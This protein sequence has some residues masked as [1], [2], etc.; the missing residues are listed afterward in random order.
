MQC[1]NRLKT[2]FLPPCSPKGKGVLRHP[3]ALQLDEIER[4][5]P[6]ARPTKNEHE[7]RTASLPAIRVTQAE[8]VL[9]EDKAATAGVSLSD[10]MRVL[11]LTEQV[12]P[13]QTKLEASLLVELNRIGV[14]LNQIA[15]ARNSGRDDPAI[16]QYAI[17]EL[18]MLMRKIDTS[19]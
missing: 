3:S 2:E 18:V 6:L 12:K 1:I 14:N 19:L 8:R 16:L 13:R 10:F 11:A 7:K 15:H 4:G 17:D 5:F 9:I